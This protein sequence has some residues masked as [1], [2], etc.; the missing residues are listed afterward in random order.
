M[1]KNKE[2]KKNEYFNKNSKEENDCRAG[3]KELA[4]PTRVLLSQNWKTFAD[5][6]PKDKPVSKPDCQRNN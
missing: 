3:T 1:R 6:Y 2:E 5:N 4:N